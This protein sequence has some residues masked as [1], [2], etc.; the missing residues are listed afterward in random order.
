MFNK[1]L[2]APPYMLFIHFFS[3]GN[4][5]VAEIGMVTITVLLLLGLIMSIIK[6]CSQFSEHGHK[7]IAGILTSLMLLGGKS[8][9]S[10]LTVGIGFY[11][12]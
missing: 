10:L 12:Y 4:I 1:D 8:F 7:V 3:L 5:L 2:N 11:Y 9:Q 6:K